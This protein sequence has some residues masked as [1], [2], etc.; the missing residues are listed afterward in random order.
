ME[1]LLPW[2][3]F[4]VPLAMLAF[5]FYINVKVREIKSAFEKDMLVLQTEISK[6]IAAALDKFKEENIHDLKKDLNECFRIARKAEK[7]AEL[8]EQEV[9]TL[10]EQCKDRHPG[11]T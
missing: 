9:E 3:Q 2:L 6:A 4:F 1:I 10:K 7:K 11:G 8:L 5:G